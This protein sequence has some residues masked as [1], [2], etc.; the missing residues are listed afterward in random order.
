MEMVSVPKKEFEQ[1]KRE[2]ETLR[3][4]RIYK[5]VL[6]FHRNIASGKRFTREDLGF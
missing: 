2:I 3:N 4:G 6:E 1:M 5:R